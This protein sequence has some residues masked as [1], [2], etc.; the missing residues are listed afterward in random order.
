MRNYMKSEWYRVARGKGFYLAFA[1]MAGLVLG[2]N[3]V[4]AAMLIGDPQ[5]KYA[6]VRFSLNTFTAQGFLVIA[7][8]R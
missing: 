7:M 1:V 6:T 5:Y 3:L 8:G 4:L 2:L